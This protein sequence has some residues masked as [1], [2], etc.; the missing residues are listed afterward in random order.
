MSHKRLRGV[1]VG[2]GYFSRFQHE[3][4]SRIPE[5]EIV[6]ICDQVEEKARAVQE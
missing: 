1:S 5:V 2:A 6:A 4:W 3:A